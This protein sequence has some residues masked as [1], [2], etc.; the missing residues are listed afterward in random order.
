[1]AVFAALRAPG[2]ARTMALALLAR[3]PLGALGLLVILQMRDRGQSYGLAGLCAGACALGMAGA[4]V[5][6]GRLIDRRGQTVM[7]V[8]CSVL[9]AAASIG[10]AA[11]P[12]HA[13]RAAFVGVAFAVGA[14]QPPVAACA[15]VLW[16]RMLDAPA[17]TVVV[18]VD[19]TLQEL[20]FVLGPVVLV[21]VATAIGPGVTLGVTGV[22]LA[23]TTLVFALL[24]ETRRLGVA[25]DGPAGSP[26]GALGNPGIRTLLVV[27]GTLGMALGAVELGIVSSA[28]HHGARGATGLLYAAWG[29]GSFVAGL[30]AARYWSGGDPSRRAAGL[31]LAL[32]ASLTLL[33]VLPGMVL[34]TVGLAI[35]GATIAPLF[36]V[37]Y[38]LVGLHA[39]PGM[40]TESFTLQTTALM[41]GAAGGAALAGGVN[42]A[43]GPPAVFLAAAAVMV[44]GA[45]AYRL[46]GRALDPELDDR[47]RHGEEA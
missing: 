7:L 37:T 32:A 19:A 31:M 44:L 8:A 46:L 23:A 26:L 35:S 41:G 24:P 6:V 13:P 43:V 11:T 5:V 33:S 14:A 20:A 27:T 12:S 10:F 4:A 17:F 2:M 38:S 45:I 40:A 36:G 30:L 34:L 16:Q 15:R 9:V 21:A 29:I 28:E 39:P 18:T 25:R 42:G 3:V 47:A 22:L 1:M